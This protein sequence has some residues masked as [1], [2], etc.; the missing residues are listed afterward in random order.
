MESWTSFI[1]LPDFTQSH[2]LTIK[3]EACRKSRSPIVS[4]AHLEYIQHYK[5]NT[6]NELY[7]CL[8][9]NPGTLYY[10]ISANLHFILWQ[11]HR[12]HE[13]IAPELGMRNDFSTQQIDKVHSIYR[14]TCVFRANNLLRLIYRCSQCTCIGSK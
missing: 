8:Q 1:W 5:Q 7:F 3:N 12:K 9:L 6:S 11:I 13:L 14:S 4:Q 2:R 10:N